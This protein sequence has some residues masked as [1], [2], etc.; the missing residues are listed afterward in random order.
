MA[1]DLSIGT[2]QFHRAGYAST[3]PAENDGV[4]IA[5]ERRGRGYGAE[6]QRLL[7]DYLLMMFPIARVEAGTEV[8][9]TA[10]QRALDK[11]GFTREGV[12]RSVMWRAGR[13]RDMVIYSRV[14]GDS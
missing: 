2:L 8:E 10:E 5:P 12:A 6:A 13:W 14:R 9:N 1:D 3:S 11:A 4:M 7:A